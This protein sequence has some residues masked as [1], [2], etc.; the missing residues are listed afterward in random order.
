MYGFHSNL[1]RLTPLSIMS[2]RIILRTFHI[3]VDFYIDL[4]KGPYRGA[5]GRG[6]AIGRGGP[7]K[8]HKTHN[9]Q[10][11]IQ[12]QNTEYRIQN[13]ECRM[14]NTEYRIQNTQYRTQNT[15][16]RTQNTEYRIQNTEHRTQNTEHRIQNPEYR[17]QN[18]A[19]AKLMCIKLPMYLF[20]IW[21]FDLMI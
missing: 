1:A 6:R 13:A 20:Y 2:W 9:I 12:I 3:G 5:R 17:I 7:C 15:E 8:S 16:H 11:R 14:Q 21:R 19:A 4:Y 10:H 18:T